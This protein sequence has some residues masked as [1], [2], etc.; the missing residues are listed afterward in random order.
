MNLA[1]AH[2][3]ARLYGQRV[4]E[5]ILR[6]DKVPC[7]IDAAYA[8]LRPLL[9]GNGYVYAL[10]FPDVDYGS[11]CP[12]LHIALVTV[13]LLYAEEIRIQRLLDV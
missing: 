10:A 12:G 8:E 2:Y 1:L 9:D 11:P 7:N 13:E 5:L 6:L 3:V 4:H